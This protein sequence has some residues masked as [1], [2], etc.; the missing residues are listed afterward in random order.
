MHLLVVIILGYFLGSIPFG[1][2]ISRLFKGIDIREYGSKGMGFTNVFRV[3]G[4]LPALIVLTLDI[5][6]GVAGVLLISQIAMGQ[7]AIDPD[8][9]KIIAGIFVILGHIFPVFANFRGGKGVATTMGMFLALI[10]SEVILVLFIFLTAVAFTRY[11]SIGSLLSASC[12]PVVLILEKYYTE[13]PIATELIIISLVLTFLIF[14]THR[15]NIVRLLKGTE[16]K[17]GEKSKRV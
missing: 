7:I 14:Y 8:L 6:K 17:F 10:P 5:G 11:I 9:I 2:I 13:K 16:N 15:Q 4:L 12:L 1:L 3:V